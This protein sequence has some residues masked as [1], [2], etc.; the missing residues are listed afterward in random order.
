MGRQFRSNQGRDPQKQRAAYVVVALSMIGM[1]LLLIGL[2]ISNN[3]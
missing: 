3:V 2:I 1:L